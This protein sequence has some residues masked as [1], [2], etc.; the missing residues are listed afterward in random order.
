MKIIKIIGKK[1]SQNEIE[2]NS[3][4]VRKWLSS[5]QILKKDISGKYHEIENVEET[6]KEYE[7]CFSTLNEEDKKY[8]SHYI[9]E[10]WKETF[11]IM[12]DVSRFEKV[13]PDNGVEFC[14]LL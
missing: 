1:Y 5:A 2:T 4:I 12:K 10:N 13:R 14:V 9:A 7:K 6:E 11:P 3:K 8:Y